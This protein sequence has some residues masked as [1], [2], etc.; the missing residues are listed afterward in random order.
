MQTTSEVDTLSYVN[1][2]QDLS[3]Q[4]EKLMHHDN[5]SYAIGIISVWHIAVYR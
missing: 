5:K 2:I 4:Y 1:I 3:L